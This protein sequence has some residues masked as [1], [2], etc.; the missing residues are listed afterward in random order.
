MHA[1]IISVTISRG[2]WLFKDASRLKKKMRWC[3]R[4]YSR[5]ERGRCVWNVC[6]DAVRLWEKTCTTETNRPYLRTILCGNT[7]KE[8]NCNVPWVAPW[9]KKCSW[10]VECVFCWR[11][12]W[13]RMRQMETNRRLHLLF[14]W[15]S[16]GWKWA[17][18]IFVSYVSHDG[19]ILGP[20]ML[21]C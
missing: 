5:R 15:E 4:Y 13:S 6:F 7:A 20:T 2:V 16:A 21:F 10:R 3:I 18:L 14:V 9:Q 11:R 12:P 8:K 19:G 17:W 1:H